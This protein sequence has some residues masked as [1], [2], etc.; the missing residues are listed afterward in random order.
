MSL[1]GEI[2]EAL[3]PPNERDGRIRDASHH[4]FWSSGEHPEASHVLLDDAERLVRQAAHSFIRDWTGDTCQSHPL[5]P[6]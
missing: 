6:E 3:S 4:G 2:A 5:Q 1:T